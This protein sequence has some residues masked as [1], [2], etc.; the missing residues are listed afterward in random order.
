MTGVPSAKLRGL[1]EDEILLGVLSAV[2]QNSHLTQR[3]IAQRLGIALGLAN[4]YLR[5]CAR[6][7]FIKV[8][9]IPRRRYAYYLTPSGFSEKSR[10]TAKYLSVSF[11]FFRRARNDCS[12]M[13][14]DLERLGRRRVA[15][16]GVCEMADVIVLCARGT[17]MEVLGIVDSNAG[18]ASYVGLPVVARVED[19]V[20]VDAVIVADV[21]IPTTRLE[22]L[23]EQL[24]L[25]RVVIPRVLKGALMPTIGVG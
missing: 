14:L 9:Q 6:K 17:G 24:G 8:Q 4:A 25:Q 1:S 13:L 2:D 19:L 23:I 18:V 16:L 3:T 12:A 5:R 20:R 7:G 11:D 15:I 22:K 10:L 21:S